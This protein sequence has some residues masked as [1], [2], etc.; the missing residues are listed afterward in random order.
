M[1]HAADEIVKMANEIKANLIT[2][3]THVHNGIIRWVKGGITD[4]V[5]SWKTKF[6]CYCSVLGRNVRRTQFSPSIHYRLF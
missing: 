3:S 6:R 2:M 1:G 5:I 4:K